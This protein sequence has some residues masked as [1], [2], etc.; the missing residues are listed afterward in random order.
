MHVFSPQKAVFV[1][2]NSQNGFWDFQF[3][4]KTSANGPS[5]KKGNFYP[6]CDNII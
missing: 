2:T 3:Y 6:L 5:D 4:L 1:Y